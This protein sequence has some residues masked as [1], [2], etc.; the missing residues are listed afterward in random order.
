M[1]W[2]S[3]CKNMEE[4]KKVY[5]ELVLKHHP[6]RGGDNQTM[7]KINNEYGEAFKIL[8]VKS[9]NKT[10]QAEK[11][12]EYPAIINELLNLS[13]IQIEICG[14]W[15]W[16]SGNTKPHKD[17]LKALGCWWASKKLMWYWRPA[18]AKCYSRGKTQT[19]DQIRMKYGSTVLKAKEREKIEKTA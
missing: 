17:R 16:I 15:L 11:V 1:K 3:K 5:K 10:E 7:A 14:A 9:T 4:L 12:E 8:Q 18:E 19:M 13:G 6:D 2:F